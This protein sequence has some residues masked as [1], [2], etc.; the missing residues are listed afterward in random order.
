MQQR[1]ACP[2]PPHPIDEYQAYMPLS[3]QTKGPPARVL[4]VRTVGE[5]DDVLPAL[6]TLV[7]SIAP[8]ARIALSLV[9]VG[10]CGVLSYVVTRRTA[11]I[12][13]R[14]AL[15]ASVGA[16]MKMIA[17]QACLP[18]AIGL[19]LGFIGAFWLTRYLQAQLYEVPPFDPS[20]LVVVGIVLVTAGLLAAAFPARRAALLDPVG[21]LRRE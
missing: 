4:G 16:V 6:R 11:E 20:V 13:V 1:Q 10:V 12:G 8:N 19:A 2:R 17:R 5:P 14:I 21:A 9:V 7:R 15:G 18:I 3:Q